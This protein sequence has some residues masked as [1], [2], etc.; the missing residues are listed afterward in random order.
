M[1]VLVLGFGGVGRVL[2]HLLI[3]DNRV[4]EIICGDIRFVNQ[5]K[6]KKV[7][8]EIVNVLDKKGFVEF[9]RKLEPDVAV[10]LTIPKFNEAIMEACAEAGVNYLDT[11]SYWDLKSESPDGKNPYIMEQLAFNDKFKK[12]GIIGLI[13]SGVAPGMDNLMV[14]ECAAQ[15]D[16]IDYIKIRMC[17]DTGSKEI[18]FSWNKDWL[19]DELRSPPLVYENGK[20]FLGEFFGEEEEAQ[21]PSP[22]GKRKT[23][24][25]AQDEVGSI[26]LYIKTKKLDVK[27]YDNNIDATK[28]MYALGL[29]SDNEIDV[30]GLKVKPIRVLSKL[31]PDTKP[32]DEK[33]FPKSVFAMA[34][35]AIG[36]KAGKKKVIKFAVV[37]PNQKEIEKLKLDAN[38]ITYPTAL[39]AKN[40]IM[41]IPKITD[42]CG[43]F[44][45][46]ALSAE[47]RKSIFDE[48]K[49]FKLKF[50]K[51]F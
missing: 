48:L 23:Y 24:Y 51:N 18:F 31:L 33:R 29:V 12:K 45:P 14:A 3:K 16:S 39:S 36:K 11:A 32:G 22:I 46:E 34:I 21:F 49:K 15:L 1:R 5:I 30:D 26:P 44:P 40:F 13:E 17:E 41:A 9:L 37:F 7:S 28:L 25:F 2:T 6:D 43:V 42:K 19:L 20:F 50:V 35:E 8:Y 47:V 4:K 38:F 10:N 27:I